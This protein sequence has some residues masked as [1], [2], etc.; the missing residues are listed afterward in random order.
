MFGE[1]LNYLKILQ[2]SGY[3]DHHIYWDI[4]EIYCRAKQTLP[5]Y[6]FASQYLSPL[7]YTKNEVLYTCCS[8]LGILNQTSTKI[9]SV[10]TLD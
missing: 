1:I 7:S 6:Q 8:K 5:I 9:K 10:L 2:Y 3:C 4:H